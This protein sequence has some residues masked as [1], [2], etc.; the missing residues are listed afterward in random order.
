MEPLHVLARNAALEEPVD[1]ELRLYRRYLLIGGFQFGL[2]FFDLCE[3]RF[4]LFLE[5]FDGR[6]GIGGRGGGL[7]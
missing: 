7:R 3:E 1:L 6:L 5:K 2:E 4:D